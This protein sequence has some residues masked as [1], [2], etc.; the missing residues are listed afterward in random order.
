MNS[1]EFKVNVNLPKSEITNLAKQVIREIV[2]DEINSVLKEINIRDIIDKKVSTL[3][4][5]IESKLDGALKN[6][7]RDSKWQMSNTIEN[8]IR[9]YVLEEIQ[10][11]PLTGNVYLKINSSDVQT[12]YDDYDG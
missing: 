6:H 5:K 4:S 8:E 10:M 1:N 11:K 2:E 7:I 12:G 3:D 9:K